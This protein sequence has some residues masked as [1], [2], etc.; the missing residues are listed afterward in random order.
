MADQD[1]DHLHEHDHGH[2][3][4]LSADPRP[5]VLLFELREHVPFSVTAVTLGLIVAGAI[6]ILGFRDEAAAVGAGH[7]A[8]DAHGHGAGLAML[9][10]HLFHP[11]HMLFS[12]VATSAMFF[13]YEHKAIKAIIIGLIGAIGVCGIS[14]IAMPQV[15]LMILGVH[16]PWHICVYEHP[17]LVLPF[18][19]VGVFVGVAVADAVAKS[20]IIS[21]SLHVMASTM[22]SIFYMVGPLGVIAWIDDLGKVFVFV[23]LAVMVPCCVS[24]IVFPLVMTKA[25]REHLAQ[26]PHA[27]C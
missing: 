21:H 20:T 4:Q 9:F 25:G 26:D 12:A 2:A 6:C 7:A 16:S 3:H 1:T 14:D 24:D 17:S 8:G 15:S 11:A 13:R 19:F 5:S 10:F 22:A 18:A 23:L 27:H